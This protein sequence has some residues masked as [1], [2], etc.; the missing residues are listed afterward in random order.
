MATGDQVTVK[1]WLRR[2]LRLGEGG[3]AS[4]TIHQQ[5]I[6]DSES[7]LDRRSVQFRYL[8]IAG[9]VDNLEDC[10]PEPVRLALDEYSFRPNLRRVGFYLPRPIAR[11]EYYRHGG[12][13]LAKKPKVSLAIRLHHSMVQHDEV[14]AGRPQCFEAVLEAPRFGQQKRLSMVMLQYRMQSSPLSLLGFNKQDS[15]R[16][17]V[18]QLRSS[19]IWHSANAPFLAPEQE[20]VVKACGASSARSAKHEAHFPDG[21]DRHAPHTARAGRWWQG[22]G[23][24]VLARPEAH[25]LT[26]QW[27]APAL[28]LAQGSVL[29]ATKKL[30]RRHT[31]ASMCLDSGAISV[32][33]QRA[34]EP[35]LHGSSEYPTYE[36][37]QGLITEWFGKE[38]HGRVEGRLGA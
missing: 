11:L 12:G 10:V 30:S 7:R 9:A 37:H 20:Q 16:R 28:Q 32:A 29:L 33:S 4:P 23:K 15:E 34:A 24:L 35:G 21:V 5:S 18:R 17:S 26:I 25:G 36:A 2:R 19:E 27:T 14:E 38:V 6:I 31:G 3:L 13:R 1:K 8:P 22:N